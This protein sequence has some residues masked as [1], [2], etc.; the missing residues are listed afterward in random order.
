MS[1]RIKNVIVI[2]DTHFGC[3]LGL[4]PNE[5]LLDEGGIYQSSPLQ[6][7][8]YEKW[9]FFWNEWVPKVTKGEPYYILHNGD[10]IDGV[11]HGATTT[12]TNNIKDQKA[13]A[14]QVMKPILSMPNCAGYYQIRGTEVHVGKSAC[15]EEDVA[16]E[17]GAIPDNIPNYARWELWLRFGN[18]NNLVH[19]AHHI[20]TTS[21]SA[22]ES[23]APMKEYIDACTEAGRWG[24]EP[25]DCIVRSHRHRNIEVRIATKSGYGISLVTA[26]WQL[27][28]PFVY[29]IAMGRSS[30]PQI[31]G[32]LIREGN[33]DSLF[34]RSIVWNLQ[35][36]KEEQI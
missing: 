31:G 6:K 12:I 8:V 22:F 25:P 21:S 36:T 35:R 32:S 3:K 9:L 14:V 17:L 4:C 28:T 24:Y 15:D 34:T 13:I 10:I 26:G 30:N 11:H 20:G 7:T 16:K 19:F 27:K 33:E 1:E 29:R 2:S 5:A 18:N 23:T